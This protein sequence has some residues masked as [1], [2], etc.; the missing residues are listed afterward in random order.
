MA[1]GCSRMT[2]NKVLTA[3]AGSGRSSAAVARVHSWRGS[4]RTWNRWRWRFRYRDGGR[5]ARPSV[6]AYRL[7]QRDL[8][9]PDAGNA[10]EVELAGQE[11]LL[12]MRCLHL[13]DGRPLALGT[14]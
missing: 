6:H 3:L 10:G 5:L 1:Y 7:L 11:N 12:A 4:R 9:L 2:V 14:A 8:R 13:A